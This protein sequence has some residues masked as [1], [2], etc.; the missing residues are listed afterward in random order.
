MKNRINNPAAET[1][2]DAEPQTDASAEAETDG[3]ELPF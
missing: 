1:N 3:D 2:A